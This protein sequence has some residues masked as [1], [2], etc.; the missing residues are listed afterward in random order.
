MESTYTTLAKAF[1][2]ELHDEHMSTC[3]P[4]QYS[5]YRFLL[6]VFQVYTSEAVRVV[7]KAIDDSSRR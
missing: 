5:D 2:K 4:S 3:G 7:V 6:W 1:S